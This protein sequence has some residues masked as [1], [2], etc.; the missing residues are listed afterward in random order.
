MNSKKLDEIIFVFASTSVD[1]FSRNS[2]FAIYIIRSWSL[3]L[4]K[5]QSCQ[6]YAKIKKKSNL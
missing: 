2:F 6:I 3:I 4:G 5:R 1:F